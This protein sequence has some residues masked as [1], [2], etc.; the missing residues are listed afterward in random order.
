MVKRTEREHNGMKFIDITSNKKA[1]CT[2]CLGEKRQVVIGQPQI[3][4]ATKASKFP[5]EVI[6]G[7]FSPTHKGVAFEV[8]NTSKWDRVEINIP[9][10]DALVLLKEAL[11]ECV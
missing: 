11:K 1:A 6:F 8:R 7:L 2:I 9:K 10:E 5:D 3:T 4:I